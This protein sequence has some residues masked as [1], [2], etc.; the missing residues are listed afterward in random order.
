VDHETDA[1]PS[2]EWIEQT[3][4]VGLEFALVVEIDRKHAIVAHIGDVVLLGI[5][6]HEPVDETETDIGLIGQNG[7]NFINTP[8]LIIEI[9]EPLDQKLLFALDAGLLLRLAV[10]V[11]HWSG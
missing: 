5:V 2:A 8:G 6:C 3:L 7:Q 4:A 11:H 10:S 9:L 1:L